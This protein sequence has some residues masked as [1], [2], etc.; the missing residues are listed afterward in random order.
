[1]ADDIADAITGDMVLSEGQ[2]QIAQ[3]PL[4]DISTFQENLESRVQIHAA[5][6]KASNPALYST[7]DVT[8]RGLLKQA[9]IYLTCSSLWQTILSTMTGFDAEALPPE[10]VSYD[11]AIELRD[12]YARLAT[13]LLQPFIALYDSSAADDTA[14]AAPYF[15]TA[16]L[17][18]DGERTPS[19]VERWVIT[20][21]LPE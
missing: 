3:F 20:G 1:M 6:V 2:F 16:G 10:Y 15:G 17:D 4:W 7:S 5:Q 13:E 19:M 14:F 9:I 18:Q 11:T 8:I 12:S 21:E